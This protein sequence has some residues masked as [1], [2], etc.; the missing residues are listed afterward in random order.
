MSLFTLSHRSV[1]SFSF[2]GAL[3]LVAAGCGKSGE[4]LHPVKGKVTLKNEPLK[5][6]MVTYFPDAAKG[7]KSTTN[8]SGQI[9]SDGS[10]TLSTGER[11]GAPAGWYKVVVTTTTPGMGG[12]TMPDP[13]N[14]TLTPLN[15][16]GQGPQINS[17]YSSS[18][19]TDLTKEVPNASAGAYDLQVSP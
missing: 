6:G 16:A 9:Q 15:P 12:G 10:Y 13:N 19:S 11:S 14:P 4:K 5:A 8:P 1:I 3:V 7:N 2:F 18:S 17:K